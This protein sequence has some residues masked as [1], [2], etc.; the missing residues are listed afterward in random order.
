MTRLGV[1]TLHVVHGLVVLVVRGGLLR[2]LRRLLLVV[3]VGP[4]TLTP[5]SSSVSRIGG[6]RYERRG[7]D[8]DAVRRSV[9]GVAPVDVEVVHGCGQIIGGRL[10]GRESGRGRGGR[11]GVKRSTIGL[12]CCDSGV[13]S[14]VIGLS[15]LGLLGGWGWTSLTWLIGGGRHVRIVG[16]TVAVGWGRRTREI[17]ERGTVAHDTA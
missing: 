8:S 2:L 4:A 14:I 16:R 3:I 15:L 11:G 6:G 10:C 13:V 12:R 5:S 7:V 1:P 9:A 17:I